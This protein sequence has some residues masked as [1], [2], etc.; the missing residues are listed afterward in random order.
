L[1]DEEETEAEEIVLA[2]VRWN[3]NVL[4]LTVLSTASG[5]FDS[6]AEGF[7]TTAI[8]LARH[9]NYLHQREAFAREAGLEIERITKE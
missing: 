9:M 8:H 4:T 1:D 7:S 5:V 2:P 6:L 3:W